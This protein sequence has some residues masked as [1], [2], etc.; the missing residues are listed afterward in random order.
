MSGF[1]FVPGPGGSLPPVANLA[2]L[3]SSAP[4]GATSWVQSRGVLYVRTGSSW[5]PTVVTDPR[6]ASATYYVASTGS[7]DALAGTV[8]VSCAEPPAGV[9]TTVPPPAPPR[10]VH[11]AIH[12]PDGT[13]TVP[14]VPALCAYAMRAG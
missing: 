12:A 8:I 7:S 4:E 2:A 1:G 5:R 11:F 9:M 10:Q 6:N 14:V 3:P 13:V